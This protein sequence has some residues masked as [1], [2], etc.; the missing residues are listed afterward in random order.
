MVSQGTTRFTFY[1]L[2][3]IRQPSSTRGEL[4]PIGNFH[5]DSKMSVLHSSMPCHMLSMISNI[6]KNLTSTTYL[7]IH[8][9]DKTILVIYELFFFDVGSTI[10]I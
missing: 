9:V 4:L 5:L 7:P 10:S 6:L 1:L 3:N 8:P 2:I